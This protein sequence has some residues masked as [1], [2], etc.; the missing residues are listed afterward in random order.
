MVFLL[1]G[2]SST[3]VV[4]LQPTS[5]SNQYEI[6]IEGTNKLIS[7]GALEADAHNNATEHCNELHKQYSPLS[8]QITPQGAGGNDMP[9]VNVIFSCK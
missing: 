9:K 3:R 6:L 5:K 8:K 1:S 4:K 7:I 2:C